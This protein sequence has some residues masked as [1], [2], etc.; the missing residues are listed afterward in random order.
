MRFSTRASAVRLGTF[1]ATTHFQQSVS[2]DAAVRLATSMETHP[3]TNF[4][5]LFCD[6]VHLITIILQFKMTF[7]L[8]KHFFINRNII[9]VKNTEVKVLSYRDNIQIMNGYEC[10]GRDI[11]MR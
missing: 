4:Y 10:D 8:F 2:I 9:M 5:I 7:N 3:K 11:F 1:F 6:T